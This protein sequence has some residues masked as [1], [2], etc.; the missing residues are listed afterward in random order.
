MVLP[1]LRP[2]G[3]R[4]ERA[5]GVPGVQAPPGLLPGEGRELLISLSTGDLL[6][7]GPL[8]ASPAALVEIDKKEGVTAGKL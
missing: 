3:D 6:L 1:Q 5:G 2:C 7:G 8:S 4:R